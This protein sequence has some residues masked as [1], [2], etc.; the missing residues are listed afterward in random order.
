MSLEALD[1]FSIP[2]NMNVFGKEKFSTRKGGL[3]SLMFVSVSVLILGSCIFRMIYEKTGLVTS[4]K[5]TVDYNS[6]SEIRIGE[7][8]AIAFAFVNYAGQVINFDPYYLNFRLTNYNTTFNHK[9]ISRSVFKEITHTHITPDDLNQYYNNLNLSMFSNVLDKIYTLDA[10][11]QSILLGGKLSY[12]SVLSLQME[13]AQFNSSKMQNQNFSNDYNSYIKNNIFGVRFIF[14]YYKPQILNISNPKKRF[15]KLVDTSFYTSNTISLKKIDFTSY[16]SLIP[17]NPPIKDYYVSVDNVNIQSTLNPTILF[18]LVW[19]EDTTFIYRKYDTFDLYLTKFMSLNSSVF[20]FF[21]LLSK[22]LTRFELKLIMF[23]SFYKMNLEE[24]MNVKDV[25][26]KSLI[27]LNGVSYKKI[28]KNRNSS[29]DLLN[30][31]NPEI[32]DGIRMNEIILNDLLINSHYRID[33]EAKLTP[34]E[35]NNNHIYEI[36]VLNK[37]KKFDLKNYFKDISN[38]Y[39]KK[40]QKILKSPFL[41]FRRNFQ[42]IYDK[43]NKNFNEFISIENIAKTQ[44]ELIK[45]KK[46]IFKDYQESIFNN[47]YFNNYSENKERNFKQNDLLL[48]MRPNSNLLES[49]LNEKLLNLVNLE[50]S[51]LN[52]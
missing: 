33:T 20:I 38:F 51:N 21:C 18:K 45:M 14:S 52:R 42:D 32:S 6:A 29:E 7:D 11:N 22:F 35:E 8:L 17:F 3:L 36:L 13:I 39:S 4:Y 1:L 30:K 26:L 24:D 43:L 47:Y 12:G 48:L 37:N 28:I 16:Q 40:F 2:I 25:E 44:V 10:M 34:I 5:E 41:C 46:V 23:N 15:V 50:L 9:S 31:N 49:T 27:N 19:E